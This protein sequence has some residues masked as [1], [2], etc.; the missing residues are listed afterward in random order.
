MKKIPPIRQPQ[1]KKS[2]PH[3]EVS[4][5]AGENH[6]V[7]AESQKENRKSQKENRI[8]VEHTER[9]K[10]NRHNKMRSN[11]LLW[12]NERRK[13]RN[14]T[15]LFIKI[16]RDIESRVHIMATKFQTMDSLAA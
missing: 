11:I 2:P 5:E 6:V 15:G 13:K 14:Q 9:Q 1:K 8:V 7:E 12:I 10:S 4:V 3:Q 16:A